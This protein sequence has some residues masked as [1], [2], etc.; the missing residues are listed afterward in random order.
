MAGPVRAQAPRWQNVW[1]SSDSVVR[2]ESA[3]VGGW[4]DEVREET[5][6]RFKQDLVGHGEGVGFY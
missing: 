1:D 6:H 4:R 2:S 3:G 5:R